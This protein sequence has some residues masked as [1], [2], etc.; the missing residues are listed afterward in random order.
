MY[1]NPSVPAP[2]RIYYAVRSS[3]PIKFNDFMIWNAFNNRRKDERRAELI[4]KVRK[5]LY[6]TLFLQLYNFIISLKISMLRVG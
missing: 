4:S 2:D 6:V 5:K 1:S 3:N